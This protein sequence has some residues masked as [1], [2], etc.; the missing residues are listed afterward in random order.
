VAPDGRQRR[1]A[2]EVVVM[3][4]HPAPGKVKS[5]LAAA[6]GADAAAELYRAFVLDLADR[7]RGAEIDA[8][9]AVWPPDAPFEELLPDVR[10]CAQQGRDLGERMAAVAARLFGDGV[11]GVVFLGADVPHVN[12]E[13]VRLAMETLQQRGH[14]VVLGPTDDGGYYLLGLARLIPEVFR[15]V[16]WGGP[17]VL[18]CTEARLKDLGVAY[19]LTERGFDLDEPADLHRLAALLAAGT[20]RLPRTAA[21]LARV[22]LS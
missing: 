12:L 4:K 3:A 21:A 16:E 18:P 9:W 10:R 13:A 20:M 15:D 8:W 1:A 6:I 14:E 7:L 17:R 19:R 22:G 2:V 5:R 11:S